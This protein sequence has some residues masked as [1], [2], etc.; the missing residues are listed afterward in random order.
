MFA[1]IL[2]FVVSS[3]CFVS[4]G[5]GLAQPRKDL[6]DFLFISLFLI[7]AVVCLTGGL[8]NINVFG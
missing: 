6:Y 5:V 1:S 7:G 2:L 3:V 4:M 8:I